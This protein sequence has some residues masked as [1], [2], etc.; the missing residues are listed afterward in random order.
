MKVL[1][2]SRRGIKLNRRNLSSK[3]LLKDCKY[4][5]LL[6]LR[7]VIEMITHLEDSKGSVHDNAII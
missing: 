7:N 2:R 6:F 1:I 4:S 5:R 3:R